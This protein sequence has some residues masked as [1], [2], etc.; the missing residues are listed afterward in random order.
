MV[1]SILFFLAGAAVAGLLALMLVPALNAR[2]ERLYRRRMEA[3]LPR[4]LGEFIAAKDAVRAE[5]AAQAART[6]IAYARLRDELVA[7][8]VG[9]ADEQLQLRAIAAERQAHAVARAELEERLEAA[10]ADVRNLK[11][12]LAQA[13]VN[14][15]DLERQ[16]SRHD[17]EAKAR[18]SAVESQAEEMRQALTEAEERIAA[19][20]T[21]M[22]DFLRE[23][24]G[25][26]L[27]A[28]RV[29]VAPAGDPETAAPRAVPA[30][31]SMEA[32]RLR[33][34]VLRLRAFNAERQRPG[35]AEP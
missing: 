35:D 33:E 19:L 1:E 5:M 28:P 22:Q 13:E 32:S 8:R 16:L 6:E 15:R 24:D 18:T 10:R 12:Q 4:S 2:A 7:E 14:R 3:Q 25:A 30:P 20:S 26:P 11:E 9:C 17:S 29:D 31:V 27:G 34:A 21:A 23:G